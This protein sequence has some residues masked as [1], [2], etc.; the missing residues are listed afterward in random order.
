[1][2][3]SKNIHVRIKDDAYADL[4]QCVGI[5]NVSREPAVL[6]GYAWQAYANDDP[7]KWM[8]RPI[9]A[10]LPANTEE[11]ASVVRICNRHGLKFK[12]F[13]TGWGAWNG[14]TEENVVQIDL[15][16]LNRIIEINVKNMHAV[17]EPYVC[18]AQLQAEAWKVGLNT[19]IVG[20]GPNASPLAAAT[21]AWGLGH[22]GIYMSY[23]PRN[24]LGFEL[25]TPDG[26]IIKAGSWGSGLAWFMGDGPGP[27][28][29]GV[30]RGTLGAFGALGVFT[31]VCLK[32]YNWPGPPVPEVNGLVVNSDST[33][34]AC[35]K[36]YSCY[37]PNVN[38]FND[39]LHKMCEAEIGYN[40]LRSSGAA[41]LM[42]FTP[43]LLDKVLASPIMRTIFSKTLRYN[44]TITLAGIS[45]DD[46]AYQEK[47]VR[48]VVREGGGFCQLLDDF[49]LMLRL[50][51]LNTLRGTTPALVFR[52]GGNFHTAMARND[53]LDFQSRWLE[54]IA[55]QKVE[56][57]R[58]GKIL[59]DGADTAYYV[60]FENGTWAHSEMTYQ[61]DT[62]NPD[63][64]AS[65]GG[66]FLD[67]IV[68][69]AECCVEPAF[70]HEPIARSFLSPLCGNFLEWQKRISKAYDPN[71]TADKGFY[72]KEE[73]I[74]LDALKESQR[75]SILE[76]RRKYTWTDDGPPR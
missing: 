36:M 13:S 56:Y 27:S 29:R 16:R 47:V 10:I 26:E 28:L 52:R 57:A 40:A 14:C 53:A 46:L 51:Y 4:E 64:L 20:A 68:A 19:N 54:I 58:E 61:Y 73:E 24:V 60:P 25:V 12:P 63:Q 31:K 49:P 70:V 72:T 7:G 37:F 21:S 44:Y 66:I 9:A 50:M 11:V 32:L 43:R 74:D 2:K 76:I 3:F 71:E 65:L 42:C 33:K 15:R 69:G 6:D 39:A 62:L 45:E 38:A 75:K 35:V 55:E 23:S 17:I 22:S 30:I 67:A 34:P 5:E 8:S 48:T 59:D 1:M 41:V 18:G